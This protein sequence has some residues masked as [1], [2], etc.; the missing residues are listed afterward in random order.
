MFANAQVDAH[1]RA[2]ENR[3]FG[4]YWRTVIYHWRGTINAIFISQHETFW[5]DDIQK[6]VSESSR[7]QVRPP[8][9]PKDRPDLKKWELSVTQRISLGVIS[10]GLA[11]LLASSSSSAARQ[12]QPAGSFWQRASWLRRWSGRSPFHWNKGET[13]V[14]LIEGCG[15]ASSKWGKAAYRNLRFCAGFI[16]LKSVGSALFTGLQG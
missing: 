6:C 13:R 7:R 5:T 9:K 4:R 3:H 10:W 14:V 1:I 16:W 11:L 15:K 2:S 8:L 12:Y